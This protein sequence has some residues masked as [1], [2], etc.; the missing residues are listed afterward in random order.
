MLPNIP[1]KLVFGSQKRKLGI[2]IKCVAEVI[3][4]TK[5]QSHTRCYI[6]K[7]ENPLSFRT[8]IKNDLKLDKLSTN[9]KKKTGGFTW[10]AY[11]EKQQN[12]NCFN[13]EHRIK[14]TAQPEL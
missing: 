10:L 8:Q 11:I 13:D 12:S 3:K 14:Y 2:V 9:L 4:L 1:V 5:R 6:R 7:N